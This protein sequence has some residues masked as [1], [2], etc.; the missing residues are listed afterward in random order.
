MR[1]RWISYGVVGILFGIFDFYYQEFT[2][3]LNYIF[4]KNILIWFIVAWGIWLIPAIL[5]D[6]YEVK[7]SKN[8]KKPIIANIFVWITAVFSYYMWIPIKWVFI[9]QPSMS[10][11][12]ISNLNSEYYFDNLKNIFWGLMTEDAPEWIV[13]AIVG[14]SVIGFLVGFSYM[15]LK[16]QK[17]E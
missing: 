12:H 11:M 17:N 10:Y 6:L 16:R 5:I 4:N 7:T 9:G 13:V 8:I 3:G 14:G 2:E 1:K 15:H